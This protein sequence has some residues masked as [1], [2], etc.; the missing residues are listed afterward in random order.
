MSVRKLIHEVAWCNVIRNSSLFHGI[1]AKIPIE[2]LV[3]KRNIRPCVF[4]WPRAT[5][6]TIYEKGHQ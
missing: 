6:G 5:R 1:K 3:P 2:T 4:S